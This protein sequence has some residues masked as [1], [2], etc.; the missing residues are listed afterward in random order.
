MRFYPRGL[1]HYPPGETGCFGSGAENEL[2]LRS[3]NRERSSPRRRGAEPLEWLSAPGTPGS[4]RADFLKD[5]WCRGPSVE[6]E[7]QLGLGHFGLQKH[8]PDQI[9]PLVRRQLRVDF[10]EPAKRGEDGL[11]IDRLP[12]HGRNRGV[13]LLEAG[14]EAG[15]LPRQVLELLLHGP[16]RR[17]TLEV[18]ELAEERAHLPLNLGEVPLEGGPSFLEL[19]QLF[20]QLQIR[21]IHELRQDSLVPD[22]LT[23][24][25]SSH[26]CGGRTDGGLRGSRQLHASS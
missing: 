25:P 14:L 3:Q 4:R 18:D 11:L 13:E 1:P 21:L 23:D 19:R 8:Q 9:P 12:L 10:L 6:R 15:A 2:R 17:G 20:L 5:P 24:T 22:D 26:R 16:E 7:A